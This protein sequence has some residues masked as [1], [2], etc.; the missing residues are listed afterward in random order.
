MGFD[1]LPVVG[2][3]GGRLEAGQ[4]RPPV[5][6]GLPPALAIQPLQVVTERT[7]RHQPGGP[8]A[9]GRRILLAD[10][11]EHLAG[12]PAVQQHMV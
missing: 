6:L 4:D 7:P 1:S 8:A 12:A 10:L 9:D 11:G 3:G 2:Q 5:L